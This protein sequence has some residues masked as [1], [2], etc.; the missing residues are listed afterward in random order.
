METIRIDAGYAN[1]WNSKQRELV[2]RIEN[3]L[4]HDCGITSIQ[5]ALGRCVTAHIYRGEGFVFTYMVDSSN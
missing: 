5:Q 3:Y 4:R 1:G 2:N